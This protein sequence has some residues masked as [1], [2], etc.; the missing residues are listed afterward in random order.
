MGQVYNVACHIRGNCNIL[1]DIQKEYFI[2]LNQPRDYFFI[3]TSCIE[4]EEYISNGQFL[5]YIIAFIP[6][7]ENQLDGKFIKHDIKWGNYSHQWEILSEIFTKFNYSWQ[8][9]VVDGDGYDENE[10]KLEVTN[11][12]SNIENF[13]NNVQSYFILEGI[14]ISPVR[15]D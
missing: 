2:L 3:D 12:E 1:F 10:R 15:T 7:K 4:R 13:D 8:L 14:Y 5:W 9:I 11:N 6:V